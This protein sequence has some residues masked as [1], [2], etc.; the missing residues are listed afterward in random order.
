M[1][2]NTRSASDIPIDTAKSRQ[3]QNF[4]GAPDTHAV[5]EYT[6]NILKI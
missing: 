1:A 4:I 5:T 3:A 6:S 2:R